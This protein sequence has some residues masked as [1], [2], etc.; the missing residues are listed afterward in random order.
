MPQIGSDR[1]RSVV[2]APVGWG[3]GAIS[4]LPRRWSVAPKPRWRWRWGVAPKPR[5]LWRWGVSSE[6]WLRPR[7]LPWRRVASGPRLRPRLLPQRRVASGFWLRPRLRVAIESLL[8]LHWRHVAAE[9]RR[10]L[11]G[12]RVT[13]ETRLRPER[14]VSAKTGRLLQRPCVIGDYA[15]MWAGFFPFGNSAAAYWASFM[16]HVYLQI[17]AIKPWHKKTKQTYY[18]ILQIG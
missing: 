15:A 7:L 4:G 13:V 17:I 16:C 14:C 8:W 6:S 1:N 11:L 12:W 3:I 10:L 18:S 9:S 5:L 2:H